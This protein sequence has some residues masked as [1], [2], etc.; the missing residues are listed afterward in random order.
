MESVL[1]P[2]FQ[3]QDIL[4]RNTLGLLIFCLLRMP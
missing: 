3:R 2:R 4:D 1:S